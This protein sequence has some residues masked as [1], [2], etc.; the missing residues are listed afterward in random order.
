MGWRIVM[1][2]RILDDI[3]KSNEIIIFCHNK[4]GNSSELYP[5]SSF[6]LFLSFFS[7]VVLDFNQT[8]ALVLEVDGIYKFCWR[9]V[10][11]YSS[12]DVE[13]KDIWLVLVLCLGFEDVSLVWIN[14]L[15]FCLWY[16]RLSYKHL[17]DILFLFSITQDK[18]KLSCFHIICKLFYNLSWRAYENKRKTAYE[19]VIAVF[20][21]AHNDSSV[22]F[23]W[24]KLWINLHHN[25]WPVP[26]P[27]R[28]LN[29]LFSDFAEEGVESINKWKAV[30][31]LK[32]TEAFY[33]SWK[34]PN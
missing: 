1:C 2:L 21:Q 30:K 34:K 4:H 33:D 13:S 10:S 3:H 27:K 6:I 25:L 8:L 7:S 17:R 26:S 12:L 28:L 19:H 18:I 11:G 31:V 32:K 16:K 23:F 5:I 22:N 29:S 9:W 20:T 15:F 14:S 24:I